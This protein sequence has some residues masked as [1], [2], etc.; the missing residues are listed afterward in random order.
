MNSTLK[1]SEIG[2]VRA[3]RDYREVGSFNPNAEH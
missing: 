1:I 2:A 3:T